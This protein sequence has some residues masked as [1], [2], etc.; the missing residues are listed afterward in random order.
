MGTIRFFISILIDLSNRLPFHRKKS[1]LHGGK[2]MNKEK[3]KQLSTAILKLFKFST[4][5]GLVYTAI[6]MT[7]LKQIDLAFNILILAS[8]FIIFNK[9]ENLQRQID[10]MEVQNAMSELQEKDS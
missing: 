10:E 9:L 6:V 4:F 3:I 2:K 8:L 1:L 5:A 7:Y